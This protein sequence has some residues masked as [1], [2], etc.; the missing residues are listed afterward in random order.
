[1]ELE[2][3]QRYGKEDDFSHFALSGNLLMEI[4]NE[5]F[6]WWVVGY[7]ENPDSVDLPQWD[8]WKHRAQMP[9]GDIVVLTSEVVSSCGDVLTLK[10][11]TK[12]KKLKG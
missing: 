8:G 6:N 9:N 11:G 2:I 1:M 10:D 7:I 3:V 12:A 5:G 4:S